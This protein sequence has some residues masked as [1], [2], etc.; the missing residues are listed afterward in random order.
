M[1]RP[2]FGAPIDSMPEDTF[3]RAVDDWSAVTLTYSE[4][5][6]M[7]FMEEITNKPDWHTKVFNDEIVA[8]WKAELF[9]FDW[10]ATDLEHAYVDDA[11]F[12][13][14]CPEPSEY[15]CSEY[16]TNSAHSAFG[17]CGRKPSSTKPLAWSPFLM[18]RLLSSSQIPP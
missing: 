4:L 18:P 9:A 13:W 16:P 5:A 7:G 1:S 10:T 14:V 15:L 2:G 17:S 3:P 8:K 11:M 6:M 12:E